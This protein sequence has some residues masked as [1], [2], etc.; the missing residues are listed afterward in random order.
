MSMRF[1]TCAEIKTLNA[2]TRVMGESQVVAYIFITFC[3]SSV[4][5]VTRLGAGQLGF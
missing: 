5:A 4:S 1:H 3:D 2:T